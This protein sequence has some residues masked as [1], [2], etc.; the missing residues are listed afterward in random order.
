MPDPVEEKLKQIALRVTRKQEADFSGDTTFEDLEAD[1]MDRVQILVSLEE[2]FD[3]EIPDEEVA[4]I[5]DMKTFVDYVKTK[6]ARKEG[7]AGE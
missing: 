6:I 2:E 1:S 3:I 7:S 4:E 5:N